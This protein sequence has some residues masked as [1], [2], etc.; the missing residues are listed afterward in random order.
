[1]MSILTYTRYSLRVVSSTSTT[2]PR[3]LSELV[4][5]IQ[6]YH[7]LGLGLLFLMVAYILV[8]LWLTRYKN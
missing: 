2:I 7:M 1:M 8:D 6:W 4:A 5:T 3:T